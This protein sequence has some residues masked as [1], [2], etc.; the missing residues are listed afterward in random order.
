ML[1]LT[2]AIAQILFTRNGE[3]NWE[4]SSLERIPVIFDQ[5]LACFMNGWTIS[6][7]R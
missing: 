5:F 6:I 4:L 2:L 7:D 1:E 3:Q